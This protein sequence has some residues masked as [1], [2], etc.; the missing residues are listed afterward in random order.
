MFQKM[1]LGAFLPHK[2]SM[3]LFKQASSDLIRIVL[4]VTGRPT[5][6]QEQVVHSLIWIGTSVSIQLS[7]SSCWSATSKL[8]LHVVGTS[9]AQLILPRP[10]SHHVTTFFWSNNTKPHQSHSYQGRFMLL[11]RLVGIFAQIRENRIFCTVCFMLVG[12][13][14]IFVQIRG[15][16][17]FCTASLCWLGGYWLLPRRPLATAESRSLGSVRH[18]SPNL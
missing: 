13:W 1:F 3:A 8:H 6:C 10:A 14:R 16:R 12:G 4:I 7:S 15:N 2:G 11:G 18:P 9:K 5:G 17:I